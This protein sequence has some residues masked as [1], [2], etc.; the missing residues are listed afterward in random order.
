MALPACCNCSPFLFT[1]HMGKC[2]SLLSDEACL[3]SVSVGNLPL[4]KHVGGGYA[5]PAFS[6]WLAY[7]QF[8]GEVPF[9]YSWAESTTWGSSPPPY[10][11]AQGALPS[12]L[13]VHFFSSLFITQFFSFF[14]RWGSVC[15]GG[16]LIF[17]EGGCGR[18]S[19]CLLLT[20]GSAKLVRSQ[21][22]AAREPSWFLHIPWCGKALCGLGVQ[23]CQSF[24]S[25]WW[26]FLSGVSQHLR[27]ILL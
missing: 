23:R 7:L 24:A 1:V 11:R 4:S 18:T 21:Y 3:M 22:L 6:S 13:R 20:C 2:P 26:F 12:L 25:S 27:K 15:P 14:V 17:I 8:I 16:M 10:S 9:P 19:C 5:A